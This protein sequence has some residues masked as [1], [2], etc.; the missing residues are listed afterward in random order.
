M[1][2]MLPSK[3]TVVTFLS[4]HMWQ[5]VGALIGT[6]SLIATLLISCGGNDAD[7]ASKIPSGDNNNCQVGGNAGYVNCPVQQL[8]PTPTAAITSGPSLTLSSFV[9]PVSVTSKYTNGPSAFFEKPLILS[10]TELASI[11]NGSLNSWLEDRPDAV[12]VGG[13]KIKLTLQGRRQVNILDVRGRIVSRKPLAGGTFFL[14]GSAGEAD[15]IPLIIDFSDSSLSA[16]ALNE[17][18][19]YYRYFEEKTVT[20]APGEQEIF[21]IESKNADEGFE[22]EWLVD[23]IALEPGGKAEKYTVG[24][25]ERPFR[26]V[27]PGRTEVLYG[28]CF[29][30]WSNLPLHPPCV[31]KKP[32]YWVRLDPNRYL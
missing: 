8:P 7:P 18:L 16:T 22:Y 14:P 31:G 24:D 15:N 17:E 1:M 4:S 25:G 10:D 6:L 30:T 29:L 27:I 20:L 11:N 26:F 5:P 32:D 3:S 23:V 19:R 2:L 9:Q 13:N 21:F 28:H 12:H